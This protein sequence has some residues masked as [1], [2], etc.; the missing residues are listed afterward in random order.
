M[1]H[2]PSE[3]GHEQDHDH[4]NTAGAVDTADIAH[5]GHNPDVVRVDKA[6]RPL[7]PRMTR[8]IEGYVDFLRWALRSRSLEALRS[9]LRDLRSL[10][11][12][13][14][15]AAVIELCGRLEWAAATQ[16]D[17]EAYRCI[18][19]LASFVHNATFVYC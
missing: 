19:Q 1:M 8:L 3:T 14:G 9:T 6:L 18:D 10:A 16:T 13:F 5:T 2:E 15:M 4:L 12:T 7:V 17:E 11:R